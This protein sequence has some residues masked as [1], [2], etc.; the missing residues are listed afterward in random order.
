VV[1]TGYIV[2]MSANSTGNS[3][4]PDKAYRVFTFK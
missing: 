1:N 2:R 3:T 4:T